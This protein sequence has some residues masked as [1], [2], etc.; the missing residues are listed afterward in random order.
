MEIRV[1][2]LAL[3]RD[4]IGM[5]VLGEGAQEDELWSMMGDDF[6]WSPNRELVARIGDMFYDKKPVFGTLTID[7]SQFPSNNDYDEE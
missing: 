4:K 6:L 1:K 7:E 5:Y 3:S 2:F